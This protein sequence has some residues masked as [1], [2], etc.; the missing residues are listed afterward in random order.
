MNTHDTKEWNEWIAKLKKNG[1]R[2]IIKSRG[3]RKEILDKDGRLIAVLRTGNVGE[4]D[5]FWG[6]DDVACIAAVQKA[7]SRLGKTADDNR[8]AG[9]PEISRIIPVDGLLPKG[10]W[11][12]DIKRCYWTTL[13]N[14]GGISKKF[15]GKWAEKEDGKLVTNMAMAMA[16]RNRKT[17]VYVNG[18]LMEIIEDQMEG[19]KKVYENIRNIAAN[20]IYSVYQMWPENTLSMHTDC[21]YIDNHKTTEAAAEMLNQMGY[22]TR[23][24]AC[25]P[26]TRDERTTYMGEKHVPIHRTGHIIK[27]GRDTCVM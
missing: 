3:G 4:K 22:E 14:L 13:K 27:C 23:I 26:A 1:H 17:E 11:K 8:T 16:T 10:F 21:I 9:R 20:A 12:V 19:E 24:Y 18:K 2:F 5:R 6:K 7:I 25:R 15:Y